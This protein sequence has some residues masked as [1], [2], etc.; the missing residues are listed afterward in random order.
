MSIS[1][2]YSNS[3]DEAKEIV[4]DGFIKVFQNFHLFDE[5]KRF[6]TW[7][8]RIM[9]N[10]AIDHYRKNKNHYHHIDADDISI[11]DFNDNVIDAMSAEEILDQVQNLPPAYKVVF[12]LYVLDGYKHHE[13]AETLNISI[14]ASKSNL[15]KARNKLKIAI[16]K[17]NLN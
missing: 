14:G 6:S 12:N 16:A 10:S 11:Q 2:P 8:R 4:N 7:L 1:L 17:T 13:I 3:E 15:A 9:V 5:E